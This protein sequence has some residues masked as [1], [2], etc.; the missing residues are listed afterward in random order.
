MA[1]TQQHTCCRRPSE[2]ELPPGSGRLCLK[3][4]VSHQF[5]TRQQ[6]IPGASGKLELT[7]VNRATVNMDLLPS[8]WGLI[9]DHYYYDCPLK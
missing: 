2:W 1:Q 7:T 6:P 9:T 3:T 4:L 5:E 8:G